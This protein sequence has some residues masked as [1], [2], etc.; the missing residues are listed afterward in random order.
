VFG[1]VNGKKGAWG[2]A[3]GGMGTITQI[4]AK[5]CRDLGVEISVES[6]VAQVPLDGG[7]GRRRPPRK[8]RGDRRQPRDRQRRSEG[9]STTGCSPQ[10]DLPADF[11]RRMKGLQ[12]PARAPS[13]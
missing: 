3:V 12:G 11:Q 8:R 1:E 6:P 5:V 4:M 7:I 2:H 9:S 10:A 13:A